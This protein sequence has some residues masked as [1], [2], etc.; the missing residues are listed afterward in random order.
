MVEEAA[1]LSCSFSPS[2]VRSCQDK[3]VGRAPARRVISHFTNARTQFVL[4]LPVG[5]LCFS[6]S[7]FPQASILGN[8][9][10]LCVCVCVCFGSPLFCLVCQLAALGAR[11]YAKDRFNLFDALIVVSSLV[12]LAVSPPDILTAGD[13]G[14][15][16]GGLSA[17]RSFRVFR[18][19]KLAR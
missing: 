4:C 16:G 13:G 8:P 6:R 7:P 18:V 12:E 17:L 11:G 10:D 9:A 14:A 3:P 19:F 2:F 5:S 15:S 1:A